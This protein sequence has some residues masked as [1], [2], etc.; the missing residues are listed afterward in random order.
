MCSPVPPNIILSPR[1]SSLHF[2]SSVWPSGLL[3]K[4]TSTLVS[5]PPR[6][7]EE[8]ITEEV[9][10]EQTLET[11]IYTELLLCGFTAQRETNQ[12]YTY[13]VTPPLCPL[14]VSRTA[15]CCCHLYFGI[16]TAQ[17]PFQSLSF[18]W[19]MHLDKLPNL[20]DCPSAKWRWQWNL[21]RI[22]FLW[23]INKRSHMKLSASSF[24]VTFINTIL[25]QGSGK[26]FL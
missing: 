14:L 7:I 15:Q 5:F 2:L 26:C 16:K 24:T 12:F 13:I 21:P 1:T 25:N 23:G 19:W 6:Q 11:W 10:F 20:S 22:L 3:C 18:T 17:V 4:G 9:A 8:D